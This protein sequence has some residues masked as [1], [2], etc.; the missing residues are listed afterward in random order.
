MNTHV[1]HNRI[2][3]ETAWREYLMRFK[4]LILTEILKARSSHILHNG[5]V[6]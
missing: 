3:L 6:E 4:I 2:F 1:L 5:P